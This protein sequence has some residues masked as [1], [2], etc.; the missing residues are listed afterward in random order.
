MRLKRKDGNVRRDAIC[1]LLK[2]IGMDEQC[3]GAAV[4][5][6]VSRLFAFEVPIQRGKV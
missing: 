6:Y 4:A 5:N 1:N 2:Q 3:F